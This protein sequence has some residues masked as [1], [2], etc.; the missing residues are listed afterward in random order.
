MLAGLSEPSRAF[1]ASRCHTII[2]RGR[3]GQVEIRADFAREKRLLKRANYWDRLLALVEG[4][5]PKYERYTYGEK[6][7]LYT[8]VLPF[9][10]VKQIEQEA[11]L[12]KYTA[13]VQQI[14]HLQATSAELYVAR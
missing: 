11:D 5:S 2:L 12:L 6:A 9:E 3:R 1:D 13:V 4:Q 10:T 8:V 7:D 14:R